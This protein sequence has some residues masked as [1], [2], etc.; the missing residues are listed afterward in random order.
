MER[1]TLSAM[2]TER[3]KKLAQAKSRNE[4]HEDYDPNAWKVSKAAQHAQASQ[5]LGELATPIAR[6][7]RAKKT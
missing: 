7:C 3:V 4:Q 5:R 6:K 1:S 2:A